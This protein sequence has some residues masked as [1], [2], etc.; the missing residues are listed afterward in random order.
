MTVC[1]EY[2]ATEQS[3]TLAEKPPYLRKEELKYAM[4]TNPVLATLKDS[5]AVTQK[6]KK[7]NLPVHLTTVLKSK[8]MPIAMYI[9]WRSIKGTF[10]HAPMTAFHIVILKCRKPFMP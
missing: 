8:Q 3:D 9:V 7:Y 10:P 1:V 6:L 5:V 4:T 2:H